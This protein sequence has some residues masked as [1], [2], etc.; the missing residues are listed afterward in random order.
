MTSLKIA[1][2]AGPNIQGQLSGNIYGENIGEIFTLIVRNMME[3][4][5][6]QQ[7]CNK[8]VERKRYTIKFLQPANVY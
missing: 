1:V 2:F 5:Y 3:G 8:M 6:I 4:K 7:N